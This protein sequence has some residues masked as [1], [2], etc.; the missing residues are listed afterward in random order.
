MLNAL[1]TNMSDRNGAVGAHL[2]HAR[3]WR[4]AMLGVIATFALAASAG[5]TPLEASAEGYRH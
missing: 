1:E 5:A 2:P 4:A 3:C